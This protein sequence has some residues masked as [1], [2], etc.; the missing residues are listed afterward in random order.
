[1]L[2]SQRIQQTLSERPDRRAI[3]F[4]AHWYSWREI[5]TIADAALSCLSAVDQSA[6]IGVVV[7]NRVPHAAALLGLIGAERNVSLVYAFQSPQALADELR[8]LEAGAIIAS[9]ED[10]SAEARQAARERNMLGL[11]I[12]GFTPGTVS[13]IE[14]AAGPK[15]QFSPPA[16]SYIEVLTSGTT[17]AP[18]RVRLPLRVLERAVSSVL[19]AP[20]SD[21]PPVQVNIWPFGGVGG[22]CMLCT[23]GASGSPLSLLE[24]FSAPDFISAVKRNRPTMMGLS[25]TALRMI[26]DANPKRED[27]D[28]VAVVTGG[29]APL[30]PDLQEAF[31]QK[32][33]I[34]VLWG[35]GATEFC[36]TVIRWTDAARQ[37]FGGTKRG[38]IGQA[39]PG[40]Q[41]RATDPLSGEAVAPGTDG[42]LEVLIPEI[43]PDWLRTT[44]LV[45]IDDD[46][47]VFHHGRHDGAIIRG[48]F[49]IMPERIAEVLRRHAD[50]ADAAIIG[51]PDSRLGEVPVAA[52]ELRAGHKPPTAESL[53][54]LVR[55]SLPATYVPVQYQFCDA[56]P[57][58]PS[59][60]PNLV[61]IRA[62]FAAHE[63]V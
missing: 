63:D 8:A 59:L 9:R 25:P 62:F 36:G 22:L 12:D 48:G 57:R 35:Y 60:K 1:M 4:L 47:F 33:K 15:R 20:P 58:T 5:K 13:I 54:T 18:K 24:K 46:G 7:R 16:E 45:S 21:D 44:D 38:S 31:E 23:N 17:G 41:I 51:L 42:L 29:S 50:I 30:D 19:M 52:I 43:N 34:P 11:S 3:E 27:F 28:G 39:M 14:P 2:L 6:P 56:L 53:D 26:M 55:Q 49:K 32:Y 40:V 37:R 10:W 61:A